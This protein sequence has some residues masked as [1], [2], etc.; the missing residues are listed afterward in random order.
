MGF[1]DPIATKNWKLSSTAG[2]V[3]GKPAS[4][5][6]QM[7][8]KGEGDYKRRRDFKWYTSCIWNKNV[9]VLSVALVGSHPIHLIGAGYVYSKNG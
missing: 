6:G 7:A 9:L 8:C 3:Y 1:F 2:V 5:N 4:S